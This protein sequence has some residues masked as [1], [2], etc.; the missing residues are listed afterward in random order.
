[1][2]LAAEDEHFVPLK[3]VTESQNFK[4]I[5]I[6]Y[7]SSLSSAVFDYKHFANKSPAGTPIFS[8]SINVSTVFE[9]FPVREKLAW[10]K[11]SQPKRNKESLFL[12]LHKSCDWRKFDLVYVACAIV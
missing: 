8:I 10:G 11:N 9:R 3:I 2:L 1:M 5:H 4:F 7:Q 12:S 6:S